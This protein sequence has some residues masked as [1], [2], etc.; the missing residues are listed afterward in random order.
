MESNV[1]DV[2][3]K[4][5]KDPLHGQQYYTK[6]MQEELKQKIKEII[7]NLEITDEMSDYEKINI[8][9]QY[10]KQ[11][12]KL[13]P[14]YFDAMKG[15]VEQIPEEE[16]IYRTGY[17]ALVKGE[18]MCAAFAEG[19]RML[20]E[21]VGVKTETHLAMVPDSRPGQ[22]GKY[23]KFFHYLIIADCND[24]NGD[25]TKIILDPERQSSKERKALKAGKTLEEGEKDFYE[26][27][28]KIPILITSPKE[29]LDNPTGKNG[30]GTGIDEIPFE[31]INKAS[32][33]EI[34]FVLTNPELL[35]KLNVKQIKLDSA[36]MVVLARQKDVISKNQDSKQLIER[37]L[38]AINERI[39][40]GEEFE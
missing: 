16:L 7:D 26:Y 20:L 28:D 22:E 36:D 31:S 12:V 17:A 34:G 25:V 23:K 38:K 21:T 29:F 9:N 6:D 8:I 3:Q 35:E 14:Q 40:R 11:N 37:F 27:M 5:S 15:I 30:L 2:I 19:A 10:I 39:D 32:I 33:K 24:E 13:R 18:G 4:I 1:S